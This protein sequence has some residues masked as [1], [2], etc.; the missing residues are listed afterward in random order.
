MLRL[1]KFLTDNWRIC[2]WP[3]SVH[4]RHSKKHCCATYN[5]MQLT[6]WVNVNGQTC[7]KLCKNL[8]T[9]TTVYY[10]CEP[11][12][13][14]TCKCGLFVILAMALA[15]WNP[16]KGNQI[17]VRTVKTQCIMEKQCLL[18][19]GILFFSMFIYLQMI[20]KGKSLYV[21]C[22]CFMASSIPSMTI[23]ILHFLHS[24]AEEWLL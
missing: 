10:Y 16:I 19:N 5:S 13:T 17:S 2:N 24:V 18:V 20:L 11:D 15:I 1:K 6:F 22:C 4:G 3:S 14:G 9:Y 8:S 23:T 12:L 7:L 21:L